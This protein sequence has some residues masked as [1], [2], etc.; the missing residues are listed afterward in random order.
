LHLLKDNQDNKCNNL[1]V[2][3]LLNQLFRIKFQQQLNQKLVFQI[4]SNYIF[5]TNTIL[6]DNTGVLS[7]QDQ[8]TLLEIFQYPG[9]QEHHVSP[10]PFNV[11]LEMQI[12]RRI[13]SKRYTRARQVKSNF[14]YLKYIVNF[15]YTGTTY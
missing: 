9:F 2:F 7:D 11:S 3:L 1:Q 12:M 15:D 10:L 6:Q 4:Q 13:L 8:S 14:I 5:S